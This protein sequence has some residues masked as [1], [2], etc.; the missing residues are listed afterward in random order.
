MGEKLRHTEFS[1]ALSASG[2][3]RADVVACQRIIGVSEDSAVRVLL[4]FGVS[5]REIADARGKSPDW[6]KSR[7]VA[8]TQVLGERLAGHL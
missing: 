8:A 6:K 2:F 1:G 7:I 4:D 3:Q 5:G